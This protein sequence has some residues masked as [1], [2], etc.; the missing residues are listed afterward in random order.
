MT[1]VIWVKRKWLWSVPDE[2]QVPAECLTSAHQGQA[3]D[4]QVIFTQYSTTVV[5]DLLKW[6]QGQ[7]RWWAWTSQSLVDQSF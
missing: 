5:F 2:I 1:S 6:G 3:A 4:W 7:G